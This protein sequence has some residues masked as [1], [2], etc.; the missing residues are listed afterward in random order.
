[1]I[2]EFDEDKNKLIEQIYTSDNSIHNNTLST[3]I[4]SLEN[5]ILQKNET[6]TN[7]Q[8]SMIQLKN[9]FEEK[10][11]NQQQRILELQD[12]YIKLESH[13]EQQLQQQRNVNKSLENEVRRKSITN[14]QDTQIGML[15]SENERLNQQLEDEKEQKI[16]FTN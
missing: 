2:T 16:F 4:E 10:F 12:G 5:D 13:Y 6:I 3:T 14:Q 7:L 1:V 8:T 15:W 11:K 9:E